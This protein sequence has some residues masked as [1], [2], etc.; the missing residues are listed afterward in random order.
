MITNFEKQLYNEHLTVSK[1][2]KK[3]PYKLRKDFSDLTAETVVA[4]KRISSL[5][6]RLNHIKSFN[7]FKAPFYLYP[8]EH[9][10][11]KF[12]TSQRALKAYTAYMKVVEESDPDSELSLEATKNALLFLKQFF[13]DQNITLDEY[14][15]QYTNSLPT[16]LLH[17]KERN[18][19]FY[20][21]FA[22]PNAEAELKKQD[23][24]IIKFMFGEGFYTNY[25]TY[26]TKFL[27]SKK[28]KIFVREGLKTIQTKTKNKLETTTN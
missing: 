12:F 21:I 26:F 10:N 5:L 28:C 9:F 14:C 1:L 25:S 22:L 18:I 6:L 2:S 11:L 24:D 23:K 16:F 4:L 17:L 8:D 7:F 13:N 27:S 15:L 3:Q 19:N 20:S